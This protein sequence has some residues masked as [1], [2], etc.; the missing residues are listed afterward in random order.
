VEEGTA[1]EWRRESYERIVE[2]LNGG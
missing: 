1:P 2:S